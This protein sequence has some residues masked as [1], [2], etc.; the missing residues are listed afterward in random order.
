MTE[1]D[2]LR[3]TRKIGRGINLPMAQQIYSVVVHL[4]SY[5]IVGLLEAIRLR[6]GAEVSLIRFQV[7]ATVEIEQVHDL[8]YVCDYDDNM[9][10]VMRLVRKEVTLVGT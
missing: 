1:F 8:K 2:H 3:H 4:R 5:G 7:G 10:A 9:V 6:A